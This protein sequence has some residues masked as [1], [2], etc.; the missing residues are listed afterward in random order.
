MRFLQRMTEGMMSGPDSGLMTVWDEVC[1][2]VQ[3]QQSTA[4]DA[5]DETVRQLVWSLLKSC[6]RLELEALWLQTDSGEDWWWNTGAEHDGGSRKRA[7]MKP[8]RQ[9]LP[10]SGQRTQIIDSPLQSLRTM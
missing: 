1:V 6:S 7:Q 3:D 5:Y 9:R 10:I 4:W 8:Q 2:Q